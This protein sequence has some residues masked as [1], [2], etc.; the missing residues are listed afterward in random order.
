MYTRA[1]RHRSGATVTMDAGSAQELHIP[2]D[3]ALQVRLDA[4]RTAQERSR[5]AFFSTTIIGLILVTGA[6]NAYLS[7]YRQIAFQ[8][9]SL[10]DANMQGTQT[11][12]KEILSAW[13]RSRMINV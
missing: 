5:L 11:L 9:S 3:P 2:S 13:V 10:A 12:Q 6:W 7:F 8:F 4:S 1:A